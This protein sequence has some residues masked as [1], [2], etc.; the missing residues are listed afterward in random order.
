MAAV[1]LHND[2]DQYLGYRGSYLR[3]ASFMCPANATGDLDSEG[4]R[5]MGFASKGSSWGGVH[6]LVVFEVGTSGIH[7]VIAWRVPLIRI[8]GIFRRTSNAFAFGLVHGPIAPSKEL[9]RYNHDRL[10]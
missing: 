3:S 6:G 7:F 5:V 8:N 10:I 1:H 9:F 4:D 2:T